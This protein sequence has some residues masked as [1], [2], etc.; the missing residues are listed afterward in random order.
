[1]PVCRIAP[2]RGRQTVCSPPCRAKRH[3]QRREENQPA[4]IHG[5][6]SL[7]QAALATLEDAR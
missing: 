3:R 2:L 7:L 4:M 5:V 1:M 6:R